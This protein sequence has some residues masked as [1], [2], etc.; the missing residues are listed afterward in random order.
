MTEKIKSFR[1]ERLKIY[2]MN[3]V[4]A[5]FN[6]TVRKMTEMFQQKTDRN[7]SVKQKTD[8]HHLRSSTSQ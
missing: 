5:S 2:A 1:S 8:T 4:M 3:A 7:V 6:T